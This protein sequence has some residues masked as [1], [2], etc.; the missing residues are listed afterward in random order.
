M[1]WLCTGEMAT[2]NH[3]HDPINFLVPTFIN[4]CVDFTKH[5]LFYPTESATWMLCS[6]E[7]AFRQSV[8]CITGP[9]SKI[10]S[11][12]GIDGVYK[13]LDEEGKKVFTQAY[14]ASFQ[15]CLDICQEIYDDVA[16]GN[17]I[18]SVVQAVS[19]FD[20]FPMGKI[21]QTHMWQVSQLL[22]IAQ[23]QCG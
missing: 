22:Q 8:E 17:E 15:P 13:A 18:K 19:R 14:C 12:D 5:V 10:I 2:S 16:S 3:Q 9:I 21:D 20:K 6:E 7:E 23:F 4:H 11:R 1:P